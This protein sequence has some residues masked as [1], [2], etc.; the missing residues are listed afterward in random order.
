MLFPGQAYHNAEVV[1]LR[2]IQEPAGRHSVRADCVETICS[3]LGEIS[4]D[5]FWS[6]TLIAIL[7]CAEG[8]IGDTVDIH[9]L[10]ADKDEFA[11]HM[12]P[13]TIDN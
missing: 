2:S 5:N 9:L 10:T 11:L 8:T 6:M 12:W 4:L 7:I 13:D 1:S 3:H